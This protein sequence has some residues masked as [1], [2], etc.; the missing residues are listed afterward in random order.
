MLEKPQPIL[1][2]VDHMA[3]LS[4]RS[5]PCGWDKRKWFRPTLRPLTLGVP[6]TKCGKDMSIYMR[7][8]STSIIPQALSMCFLQTLLMIDPATGELL[9]PANCR[10]H[11]V[12]RGLGPKSIPQGDVVGPKRKAGGVSV[13]KP[14]S[15]WFRFLKAFFGPCHILT[16]ATFG[17]VAWG[18]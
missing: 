8:L 12:D 3:S 2:H 18:P 6:R 17:G 1:S 4:S 10:A 9:T 13:M 16:V 15:S 11:C 14:L 7:I 5:K